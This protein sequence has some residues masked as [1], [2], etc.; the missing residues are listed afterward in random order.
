MTKDEVLFMNG[1]ALGERCIIGGFSL[2][3]DRKSWGVGYIIMIC[4][5]NFHFNK[6]LG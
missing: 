5:D 1:F 4:I 3:I 6:L 2:R